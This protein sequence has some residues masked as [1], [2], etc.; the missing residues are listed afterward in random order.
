MTIALA[1]CFVQVTDIDQSIAFY[2]DSLG[3]DL[4]NNVSNDG[5]SWITVGSPTQPGVEIVLTNF[6]GGSPDD[7]DIVASLVA[8]G[9]MNGLHFSVSDLDAVFAQLR[10]SGVD[11]VSEPTD[12]PWGVRDCAV[13]DPSGNLI[14]INAQSGNES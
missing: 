6:V 4:K 10:D 9:A 14:R 12:Q 1:T 2:R 13:R 5:F 11:V 7:I 8:K 3:L